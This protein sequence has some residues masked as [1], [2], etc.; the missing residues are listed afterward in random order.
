MNVIGQI[1]LMGHAVKNISGKSSIAGMRT[2]GMVKA[3][4]LVML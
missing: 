2:L 1:I 3:V 4:T